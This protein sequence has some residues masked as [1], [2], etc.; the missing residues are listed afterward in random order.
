MPTRNDKIL[1]HLPVTKQ[2]LEQY[3]LVHNQFGVSYRDIKY[4]LKTLLDVKRSVGW[5]HNVLHDAVN[6]ANDLNDAEDLSKINVS[7]N[8]ELFDH[9]K[10]ILASVCTNSLYCPILKKTTDRKAT[11]WEAVLSDA[12]QNGYNPSSVILDGLGSLHAGHQL[13]LKDVN[14]I[15]DTFHIIKDLNDL[16]RFVSNRLKSAKTNLN[17]IMDK[18]E[19]A[20]KDEKITFLESQFTTADTAYYQALEL[21]RNISEL[22]SWIQHDILQVAGYDFNTRLA[23]LNFIADQ[24]QQLEPQMEHRI[25]P[26]RRALQ[27]NAEKL[28]GFVKDLE[29]ELIEYA[30][31][32]NCDVYWL[33]KIC[34]AQKFSKNN[35]SYYLYIAEVKSRLKHHFYQIEQTVIRIMNEIEKASSVVENLNGRIRKFLNNHIHVGQG[36]LDLLRFILNHREFER[37]RCEHRQGKS[38]AEVLYEKQHDHWLEMLGYKLFKQAA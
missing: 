14:I 5:V 20:K 1:F 16:K 38:P 30:N 31:E 22:C 8:D 26:V 19:R 32:L 24:F 9:Q 23:L 35:A 10:P 15:Y 7:A 12:I 34:Y 37:S 13:A 33:W 36:M 28:L 25:K 29:D 11:T 27:N 17:T 18:L 2:W 6:K 3:A 21:Y 4:G